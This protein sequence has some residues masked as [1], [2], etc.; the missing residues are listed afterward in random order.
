MRDN[1]DDAFKCM[2]CFVYAKGMH[3][4]QSIQSA[5]RVCVGDL[6]RCQALGESKLFSGKNIAS[7]DNDAADMN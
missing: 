5:K 1:S 2:I 3:I 7:L 4:L 6:L